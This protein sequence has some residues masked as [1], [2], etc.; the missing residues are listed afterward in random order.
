MRGWAVHVSRFG[1]AAR[2]VVFAV[3]GGFLVAAAVRAD[4]GEARGLGGA[5]A[6]LRDQ[7]YGPWLFAAAALGLMA[8]GVYGLLLARY[9]QVR[10]A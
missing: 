10:V 1:I 4:P 5:L 8:F 7:P 9:R 2:G 3:V 6:A